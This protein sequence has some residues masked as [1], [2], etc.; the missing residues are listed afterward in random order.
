MP[1]LVNSSKHLRGK[2]DTN[3]IQTRRAEKEEPLNLICE[4]II[5]QYRS[6]TRTLQDLK[7][8]KKT[9]AYTFLLDVAAKDR[10]RQYGKSIMHQEQMGFVT[11]AR[12]A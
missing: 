1:S 8:K 2:N 7:K 6:L 10:S 3:F 9:Q 4:A 5:T 11:S 12:L